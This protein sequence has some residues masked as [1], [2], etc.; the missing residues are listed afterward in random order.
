[1]TDTPRSCQNCPSFL[2]REEVAGVFG[3]SIGAPMCARFGKVLGAPDIVPVA[4]QNLQDTIASNCPGFGQ[5]QP[6]SPQ[7]YLQTEVT[8]PH[9]AVLAELSDDPA[10]D[11]DLAMVNSCLS[12]KFYAQPDEV[13]EDDSLGW[14]AG[15]CTATG[16]LIIPNR[17][18]REAANCSVKKYGSRNK[19]LRPLDDIHVIPMY[20]AAKSYDPS[21]L[22]AWKK[23]RENGTFIDPRDYP[24]DAPV[25][26]EDESYGIRA[27]R[28][29]V[30]PG[31]SGNEVYLP[32]FDPAHFSE[33][34][35]QAIPQTGSAEHPEDYI[36]SRDFVYSVAVEW[37][38]L[39][40]T[41]ALWGPPGA[42]K[43]ELGRHLAWLCQMPFYRMSFTREMEVEDII[44]K[45]VFLDG[46][47]KFQ[48]GRL[49]HAWVKPG[50]ILMDEPNAAQDAVWQ[51][52][53]P[54]T[55]NSKQMVLDEAGAEVVQ[56]NPFSF[57][58]MAMNPSWD[59]RN[60]G[61]NEVAQ[62]D[63]SRLV[64]LFMDLPT[65]EVEREILK[66]ACQH[67]GWT[68]EKKVLDGVLANSSEIRQLVEDGAFPESWGVREN[69]KVIRH[70]KW[71]TPEVAYR[72][73]V[74]DALEPSTAEMVMDIVNTGGRL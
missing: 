21:P 47:T 46:E 10:T 69:L 7:G 6:K 41:P 18:S 36:D 56:R 40:A 35:Q 44:G 29:V 13:M 27:W 72:R 11:D 8:L 53:R 16:R 38:E 30:D 5:P 48:W 37:M 43:T 64:H 52:I 49:P 65:P 71:F 14:A 20:G 55:D 26:D 9:P 70:L 63:K 58:L 23:A 31:G 45:M 54:L 61:L 50:I 2:K 32:I 12:C 67:D 22:G 25:D 28:R 34:E 24:T 17:A 42:G 74:I 3:K 1:V 59:T 19:T 57:M 15:L 68:P 62:A 60:T 51:R 73:A 4:E 66:A 33:A 39:D